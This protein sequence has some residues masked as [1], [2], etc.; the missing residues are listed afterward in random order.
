M[1][2]IDNNLLQLKLNDLPDLAEL[3]AT[4]ATIEAAIEEGDVA[5]EPDDDAEA[6]D[7]P[8]GPEAQD[9]AEP[10]TG[11]VQWVS[12]GRIG[13]VTGDGYCLRA[14]WRSGWPLQCR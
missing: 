5:A 6:M 10:E 14:A 1:P 9:D 7:E 4:S 3:A 2:T 12:R 11:T 8:A 13:L